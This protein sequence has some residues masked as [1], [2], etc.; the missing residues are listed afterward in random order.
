MIEDL[1]GLIVHLA[2]SFLDN[3]LEALVLEVGALDQFIQSVDVAIE[4][5][6]VV[7]RNGLLAHHRLQRILCVG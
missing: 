6:A 4:V 3:R 2:V 1:S 5:L 7:K